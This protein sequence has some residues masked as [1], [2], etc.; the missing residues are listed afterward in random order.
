VIEAFELPARTCAAE[1][2]MSVV[3][4]AAAA[5][6]PPQADAPVSAFPFATRDVALLVPT[7]VAAR[8]VQD[9]L[10]AGA[11]DASGGGLLEDI[12]L[13]DVYTGEQAGEGRKSLAYTLRFRAADRTLT[14]EEASAARDA[15]VAE[16]G[17]RTGAV[18]RG[19]A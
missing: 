13:F 5:Q 17:R 16:A 15:A 7:A 11:R 10:T 4:T 9:A 18:L 12:R 19:G 8:E 2:D 1:I 14:A 3:E 6:T